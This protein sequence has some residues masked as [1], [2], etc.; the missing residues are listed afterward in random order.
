[1]IDVTKHDTFAEVVDKVSSIVGPGGLDVLINNAG[2]LQRGTEGDLICTE[3][4]AETYFINTISPLVLTKAFLPLL[5]AG[6]SATLD[7][8]YSIKSAAVVNMSSFL[9]SLKENTWGSAGGHTYS[10]RCSKV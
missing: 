9:G 8:K 5:K 1:M 6:A 7:E 2:I 3:M 4:M 10:Y